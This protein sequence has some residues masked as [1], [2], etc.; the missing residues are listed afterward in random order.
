ML[1]RAYGFARA[2]VA[3]RRGD[4]LR[5]RVLTYTVTFKCNARCVMCDSWRIR[6]ADDLDLREVETIFDQLPRLDVVRLTGGEPFVRKDFP[7]VV[8][9][10]ARRLRPAA[11]Q[12]TTNG[13]LT[14]RIVAACEQRDR[15]VPLHLLVSVDGLDDKQNEVRGRDDAWDTAF[16][17]IRRLAPRRRELRLTLAVNQTIVDSEGVRHYELLRDALAPLGVPVQVVVAYDESA[18]YSVE[19]DRELEIDG[20]YAT[21]GTFAPGE[22]QGLLD[23][24]EE[25]LADAPALTRYAKRYYLRGLRARLAGLDDHGPR[26]RCV[27]LNAHLRIFPNGDVPTCQFNS[28]VVGNLR[29]QPFEEV[30]ACARADEQRRWVARCPGCW[31]ECEVLPSSCYT[32]DLFLESLRRRKPLPAREPETVTT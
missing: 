9:L 15:R 11:I 28:K 12:I 18:T 13:F 14:D 7:E 32:G 26:P 29:H 3:S 19:R 1:D 31:A 8:D 25:D 21:F 20:G 10:A 27:A 4:V 17:T 24:V 22:L 16:E 2:V 6:S 23:R 30:W 5:P